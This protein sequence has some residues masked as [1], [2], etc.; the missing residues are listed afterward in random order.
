[1]AKMFKDNVRAVLAGVCCAAVCLGCAGMVEDVRGMDVVGSMEEDI[2]PR[3][4]GGTIISYDYG[5]EFFKEYANYGF[6]KWKADGER[7][8][9]SKFVNEYVGTGIIPVLNDGRPEL[10]AWFD[11]TVNSNVFLVEWGGAREL[12][13][14]VLQ[15]ILKTYLE[16]GEIPEYISSKMQT[17][18][19]SL[20]HNFGF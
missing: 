20:D 10:A 12:T 1:M 14:D 9:T 17:A 19:D 11:Y 16:Y 3:L 18:F 7:F 6:E 8:I 13:R 4:A 15:C 2:L 5:D